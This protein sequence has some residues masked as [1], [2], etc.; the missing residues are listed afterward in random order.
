MM[1]GDPAGQ[2]RRKIRLKLNERTRH[3]ERASI[4]RE[5]G[6]SVGRGTHLRT[7]L[8]SKNQSPLAI[9]ERLKATQA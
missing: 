9:A 3:G 8:G 1:S 4:L 6:A 7:E 2:G 5:W